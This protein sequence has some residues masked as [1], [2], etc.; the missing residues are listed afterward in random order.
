M[1]SETSTSQEYSGP[2]EFSDQ[3]RAATVISH[4]DVSTHHPSS[5]GRDLT[6]GVWSTYDE[7]SVTIARSITKPSGIESSS[8]ALGHSSVIASYTASPHNAGTRE[9]TDKQQAVTETEEEDI[10]MAHLTTLDS[11]LS[12]FSSP[13]RQNI[14]SGSTD[15][16]EPSRTSY[17]TKAV[18]ETSNTPVT[19]TAATI[20]HLTPPS[21]VTS[22][23]LT[24]DS[25]SHRLSVGLSAF[26][27]VLLFFSGFL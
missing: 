23:N 14:A 26:L 3:Y 24:S 2:S 8:N 11:L 5:P 10:S 18:T 21:S 25:T 22:E 16:N 6:T 15:P 12:D 13:S 9:S 4:E 20:R 17:A 19:E 1:V 7:S 27:T